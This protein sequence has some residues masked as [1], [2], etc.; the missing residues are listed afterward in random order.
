MYYTEL[1]NHPEKMEKKP[2]DFFKTFDPKEYSGLSKD[3]IRERYEALFQKY[4]TPK[5]RVYSGKGHSF[6]FPATYQGLTSEHVT[7]IDF[8]NDK[9]CEV[10]CQIPTGFKRTIKFIVLKKKDGWLLD[11]V[12]SYS[13]SD[14]KWNNSL[15]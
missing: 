5:K 15:L 14:D 6:S 2:F 4:T 7:A 12:K 9:R 3:D 13:K 8:I 11:S 1:E 10:T